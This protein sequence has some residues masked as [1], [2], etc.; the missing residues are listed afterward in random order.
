MAILSL[1]QSVRIHTRTVNWELTKSHCL[2]KLT[3]LIWVHRYNL[4]R[5]K[6]F[7]DGN[8]NFGNRWRSI[9]DIWK[10]KS[11]VEKVR[12]NN[13]WPWPS[14][15]F[16]L[17]PLRPNSSHWQQN[18]VWEGGAFKYVLTKPD[19][20]FYLPLYD[21]LWNNPQARGSCY[22]P[23]ACSIPKK[24]WQAHTITEY[25]KRSYPFSRQAK[26]K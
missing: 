2:N 17:S 10:R 19:W 13:W 21:P 12:E 26:I 1:Q 16:N 8:I 22:S 18:R 15:C 23:Q 7:F 9:R 24:N 25:R 4:F 11:E 3:I 14:N 6:G 20:T 5:I